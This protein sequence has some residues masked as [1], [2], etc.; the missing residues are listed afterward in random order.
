VISPP[1]S[2]RRYGLL[3]AVGLLPGAVM[4]ANDVAAPT[5]EQRLAS[6]RLARAAAEADLAR[7]QREQADCEV[8]GTS[9]TVLP[10]SPHGS[11]RESPSLKIA[12]P[13]LALVAGLALGFGFSDWLQRRRHGGFRL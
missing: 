6:E 4:A 7:L 13:G 11:G 2:G 9:P 3:L 12:V 1:A 8:A 10:G 5:L